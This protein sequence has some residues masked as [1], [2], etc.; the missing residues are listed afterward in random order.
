MVDVGDLVGGVRAF[1]LYQIPELGHACGKVELRQ[2]RLAALAFGGD[3]S[4]LAAQ[5]SLHRLFQL[6]I[7]FI[8]EVHVVTTP[9]PCTDA[10]IKLC[11]VFWVA[12]HHES[13]QTL[14]GCEVIGARLWAYEGLA[15]GFYEVHRP[16]ISIVLEIEQDA[17]HA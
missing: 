6:R 16:Q 13:P 5:T 3:I 12:T 4:R 11:D 17:G 15:V 14:Q 10:A 7:L 8:S 2:S 1:A 9:T